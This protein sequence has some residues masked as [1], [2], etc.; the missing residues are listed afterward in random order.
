MQL[1]IAPFRIIE[2]RCI[3]LW[4][5]KYL[6]V[7]ICVICV[8]YLLVTLVASRIPESEYSVVL[9]FRVSDIFCC[10]RMCCNFFAVGFNINSKKVIKLTV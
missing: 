8:V 10:T 3:T 5:K 9:Y 1:I 6:E 4:S 7:G 2:R